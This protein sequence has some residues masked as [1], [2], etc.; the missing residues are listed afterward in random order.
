MW[1][2]RDSSERNHRW[3]KYD[4]RSKSGDYRKGSHYYPSESGR[5]WESSNNGRHI[6]SGRYAYGYNA[7]KGTYHCIL[8]KHTNVKSFTF[9][10][11][12]KQGKDGISPKAVTNIVQNGR[13]AVIRNQNQVRVQNR[14]Q[15]QIRKKRKVYKHTLKHFSFT[16][17]TILILLRFIRLKE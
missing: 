9:Y 2:G 6:Q 13:A 16:Y 3:Y 17:C 5:K 11:I 15:N 4:D 1:R 7:N 10:I 12:Y 8:Y 14:N